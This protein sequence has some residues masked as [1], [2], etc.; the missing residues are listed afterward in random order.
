MQKYGNLY[1]FLTN[2][3][4]NTSLNNVKLLQVGFLDELKDGFSVY[5]N[6]NAA[7]SARDLYLYLLENPRI[8]VYNLFLNTPTDKYNK[9]I[10]LQVQKLF[11]SMEDIFKKLTNKGIINNDFNQ[12][13]IVKQKYK[14]SIVKKTK[15]EPELKPKFEESIA[16]RN[17]LRKQRLNEIATKEKIIF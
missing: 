1:N 2:A 12:S 5:R 14:K 16:E 4:G 8:S 11:S 15:L 17:I 3:V 10:Y 13:S 9:E 7:N 6:I